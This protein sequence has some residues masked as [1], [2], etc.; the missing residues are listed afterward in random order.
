[1]LYK[2]KLN[3]K[4]NN[5]GKFVFKRDIFFAIMLMLIGIGAFVSNDAIGKLL[6]GTY[7][8]SFMLALR[9]L[10]ATSLLLPIFRIRGETYSSIFIPKGKYIFHILRNIVAPLEVSIFFLAASKM[11]LA[12]VLTYYL[13]SPIYTTII[14]VFFL[15]ERISLGHWLA[16]I[17]GF[18]GVIIVLKP[19]SDTFNA[20]SFLPFASS[21]SFS[22]QNVLT[23]AL[24]NET[25][26]VLIIWQTISVFVV[27]AFFILFFENIP[28]LKINTDLLLFFSMAILATFGHM[29]INRSLKMAPASYV[30]PYQYSEIIWASLFGYFIFNEVVSFSTLVG[31]LII[32]ASG[33]YLMIIEIKCLYN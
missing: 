17:T 15:K 18:I 21:L 25:D 9:G 8:V 11:P 3:I 14:S 6:L 24:K 13:A 26:S 30:V 33:L 22:F 5:E 2:V 27:S 29:C 19:T 10:I 7:S 1:M 20:Y 12:E 23:R 28:S 16:I 4:K 31:I 32:I